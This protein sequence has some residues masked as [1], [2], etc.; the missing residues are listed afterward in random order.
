MRISLIMPGLL[1]RYP[2]ASRRC[3]RGTVQDLSGLR[4]KVIAVVLGDTMEEM[5]RRKHVVAEALRLD[6][7]AQG[8]R[9][10]Q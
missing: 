7:I 4:A 3:Y 5:R 6:D 1:D 2:T 10:D 8:G 9:E